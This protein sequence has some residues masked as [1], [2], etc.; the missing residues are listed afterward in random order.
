VARKIEVLNVAGNGEQASPGIGDKVVDY[1]RAVFSALQQRGQLEQNADR[2]WRLRPSGERPLRIVDNFL[3]HPCD[4]TMQTLRQASWAWAW[5]A[6]LRAAPAGP[7][8]RIPPEQ[9][10]SLVEV[11]VDIDRHIVTRLQAVVDGRAKDTASLTE[12]FILPERDSPPVREGFETYVVAVAMFYLLRSVRHQRESGQRVARML[13]FAF[14]PYLACALRRIQR[15]NF[16]GTDPRLQ[17]M[18]LQSLLE[19]NIHY[20]MD[21]EIQELPHLFALLY[22]RCQ[23]RLNDAVGNE[24]VIEG[25]LPPELPEEEWGEAAGPPDFAGLGGH[26]DPQTTGYVRQLR[27]EVETKVWLWLEAAYPIACEAASTFPNADGR[28][29]FLWLILGGLSHESRSHVR[30]QAPETSYLVQP[31]LIE[32]LRQEKSIDRL[33]AQPVDKL[34]QELEYRERVMDAYCEEMDRRYRED[35]HP[36]REERVERA[37]EQLE[38]FPREPEERVPGWKLFQMLSDR[39]VKMILAGQLTPTVNIVDDNDW[40]AWVHDT[41]G[42][43]DRRTRDVLASVTKFVCHAAQGQNWRSCLDSFAQPAQ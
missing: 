9:L 3:S 11:A 38:R 7:A 18:A 5:N 34:M 15:Q 43:Q 30:S 19:E 31:V 29:L 28:R 24:P 16:P 1:L 21:D 35:T 12:G 23:W 26:P 6:I 4:E 40:V 41:L 36:D 20:L 27:D 2:I 42:K 13:V 14:R 10:Q 22:K 8:G 32:E 37:K 33:F 39:V 25:R 17:D